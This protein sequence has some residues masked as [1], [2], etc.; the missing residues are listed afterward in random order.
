LLSLPPEIVTEIVSL[1][2]SGDSK[3]L[4]SVAKTCRRL[5]HAAIPIIFARVS[6]GYYGRVGEER[7]PTRAVKTLQ[8]LREPGLA[9]YAGEPDLN[10]GW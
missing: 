1:L 2:E 8:L 6:L 10:R 5:H 7:D 3:D 9:R 4:F